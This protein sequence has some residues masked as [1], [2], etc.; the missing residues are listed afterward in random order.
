MA[1]IF[2]APEYR[3][4]IAREETLRN[5]AFLDSPE[6]LC[7]FRVAPFNLLHLAALQIAGNPFICGGDLQPWHVAQFLW[8]V[9]EPVPGRPGWRQR[10]FIRKCRRLRFVE[11]VG[12]IAEWVDLAFE[13]TIGRGCG[14]EAHE[15]RPYVAAAGIVDRIAS[16]YGW[17]E[18]DILK[19]PLKRLLAYQRAIAIRNDP[20]KIVLSRSDDILPELVEKGVG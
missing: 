11:S 8:V 10:R 9:R 4:A 1:D 2:Q 14:A 3:E 20:E 19:T 6:T 12:Q 13:D 7:G 17:S 18:Q 16:E 5:A 15:A